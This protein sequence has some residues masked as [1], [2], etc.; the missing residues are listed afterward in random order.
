MTNFKEPYYLVDF[1]SSACNFEIY[2]NDMPAFIQIDSGNI[3]SHVPINQFILESGKQMIKIIVKPLKN[4]QKIKGDAFLFV[5]VFSYDSS[6]TNYSDTVEVYNFKQE[7]FESYDERVFLIAGGFDV[8]VKYSVDGWKNSIVNEIIEQQLI[9][10]VTNFYKLIYN[11]FKEKNIDEL[12][13]MMQTKFTEIDSSMYINDADN[14]NGLRNLFNDLVSGE[15]EL[16]EFPSSISIKQYGEKKV[17]R[18]V[19]QNTDP[20]ICYQNL[21]TNEE[22]LFP[23]FLHKAKLHKKIEIIR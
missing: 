4:Q 12:Y 11:K 8:N 3:S 18:A 7:N 2:I 5:K 22:F 20:I 1:N 15:F 14:K 10:E 23:I 21:K 9:S 19:R 13:N 17:L 16:Q 6:T